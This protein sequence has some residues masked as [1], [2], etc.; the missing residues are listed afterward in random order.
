MLNDLKKKKKKKK[1]KKNHLKIGRLN[2]EHSDKHTQCIWNKFISNMYLKYQISILYLYLNTKK[3]KK[4]K[5]YF[6]INILYF[7]KHF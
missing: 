1:K 3:K 7:V 4:K 6:C 5:K 2:R